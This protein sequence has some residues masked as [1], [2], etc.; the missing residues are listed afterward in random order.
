VASFVY[1]GGEDRRV[2]RDQA[3][4]P[5][6]ASFGAAGTVRGIVPAAFVGPVCAAQPTALRGLSTFAAGRCGKGA[7]LRKAT[8]LR[9][10]GATTFS[11]RFGG[12]RAILCEAALVIGNVGPAFAGNFALLVLVHAGKPARRPG[13]VDFALFGHS[14]LPAKSSRMKDVVLVNRRQ[15][16]RFPTFLAELEL[17]GRWPFPVARQRAACTRLRIFVAGLGANQPG[18]RHDLRW[19]VAGRAPVPTGVALAL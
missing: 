12:K 8:R 9:C 3:P 13:G 4:W 6:P 19:P 2:Q 1:V 7:I 17:G 14:Q 5:R 15:W 18:G 11:A 10:H 16:L